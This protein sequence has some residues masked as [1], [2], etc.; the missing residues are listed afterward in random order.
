MNTGPRVAE[1][2]LAERL[3]AK[4]RD[5]FFTEQAQDAFLRGNRLLAAGDAAAAL[6][7]IERACRFAPG[8]FTLRFALGLTWLRLSDWARAAPL[9]EAVARGCDVAEAWYAL[10]SAHASLGEAGPAAAA[11][12]EL[13]SRHVLPEDGGL[14]G[15]AGGIARAAGWPGWCGRRRDGAIE[16]VAAAPVTARLNGRRL[17]PSRLAAPPASGVLALSAGGRTLLGS[18]LDLAAFRRVEGFVAATDFGL[19]GWAWHPADPQTPPRLT[20][21]TAAGATLLALTADDTDMVAPRPLTRPRRFAVPAARLAAAGGML[22]VSGP[23]GRELAGSPL[24]PSLALRPA[25]TRPPPAAV[26]AVRPAP[27]RPVAVV[28]PVHGGLRTTLAC[29]AS[30][31]ATVPPGTAVLVVDDA[32]PE[33]ELAGALDA[34]AAQ[35]RII[36]LRHASNRGFPA[37]ANAGLRAAR[38]RR[39][40][41]DAVLLNS[42]TLVAPG[43]LEGLRA[44]VHGTAD[45]GTATPFSNDATILS[46]PEANRSNPPPDGALLHRLAALAA[47]AARGRV[48]DIPTAVGF[49][50]YIRRECL[51]ATGLFREDVFAQGYGEEN[52]FCMRA[53]RLGWRHVAVPGV[54][55]A[56]VGG[57]SFGGAR[58]QLLRRNLAVLERLHPG[59]GALVAAHVRA[60]PLAASRRRLDAAR[61]RAAAPRLGPPAVL[62]VTHDSGGGVERVLRARCDALR[63][64]GKRPVVL[65]PVRATEGPDRTLPDLCLVCDG[66]ARSTPSLR[67][68]LAAELPALVRLLRAARPELDGGAQ[69]AGP[70]PSGDAASGAARHSARRA[71]ARLRLDVPAHHPGRPVAPLLRRAGGAGGLRG[72]RRRGRQQHRRSDR[73]RRAARPVGRHFCRRAPG[74]DAVDRPRR[75]LAPPFSRPRRGGGGA[76]RRRRPAAART[77]LA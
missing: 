43:W 21:R 1:L 73:H 62:L 52:D 64:E 35:G 71:C 28:V 46:Y 8:D 9:L 60:D 50:M 67:F 16:V 22:H 38:A 17:S 20:I 58:T 74:G 77:A 5:E 23:D 4:T 33:P 75:P 56:H 61:F 30:V 12:G 57:A 32:S 6:P 2:P 27:R 63:G 49:C 42:D 55:V 47:R 68:R 37:S 51:D 26:S 3:Q 45:I 59:Y 66:T 48:V 31:H 19:E 13:L 40:R 72:L 15:Q 76:H 44:A 39:G 41:P 54:F 69:P 7:W 25:D 29:L 36:L 11:L 65:R 10:A 70:P 18:P 24:D 34:L 53:R 14:S